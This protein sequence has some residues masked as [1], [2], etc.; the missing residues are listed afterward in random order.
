M[1]C[2]FPGTAVF[3]ALTIGSA[4]AAEYRFQTFGG[5][6]G[7]NSAV[8]RNVFAGP[9]GRVWVTSPHEIYRFDGKRF[10]TVQPAGDLANMDDVRW[11]TIF[12]DRVY[13]RVGGAIFRFGTK[14][15][16]T[17]AFQRVASGLPAGAGYNQGP[18]QVMAAGPDGQLW[19]LDA[20]RLLRLTD[21]GKIELLHDFQT[22][23]HSLLPGP[24]GGAWAGCGDGLC[25]WPGH[26]EHRY[27]GARE[28]VPK[29]EYLKLISRPESGLLVARGR[30]RLVEQSDRGFADTTG[31]LGPLLPDQ[32][33]PALAFDHQRRLLTNSEQGLARQEAGTWKFINARNGLASD[34]VRAVGVDV[35]GSIWLGTLSGGVLR[36]LGDGDWRAYTPADGLPRRGAESMVQDGEGNLWV[37]TLGFGVY[38]G[39]RHQGDWHFTREP[40]LGDGGILA[41]HDGWIW[42]ASAGGLRRFHPRRRRREELRQG[43]L[44]QHWIRQFAVDGA[45]KL[46]AVGNDGLFEVSAAGAVRK[47]L[48]E[49]IGSPFTVAPSGADGLWLGTGKGLFRYTPAGGAE[50]VGPRYGVSALGVDARG[51]LWVGGRQQPLVLFEWREG[52]FKRLRSENELGAI[53]PTWLVCTGEDLWV[54]MNLGIAARRSSV[55]YHYGVRGAPPG[56]EWRTS[57]LGPDGVFYF[58]SSGGILQYE[59]SRTQYRRTPPVVQIKAILIEGRSPH[60]GELRRIPPEHGNLSVSFA[61]PT[62]ATGLRHPAR[63][64]LLPN[65]AWAPTSEQRLD[66]IGL[67]PG[68]YTL[69][70]AARGGD[71]EWGRAAN[72]PIA[73]LPFWYQTK[74]ALSASLLLGAGLAMVA[75]YMYRRLHWLRTWRLLREVLQRFPSPVCVCGPDGQLLFS[76]RQARALTSEQQDLLFGAPG[77]LEVVTQTGAEQRSEKELPD[78]RRFEVTHYPLFRESG[79]L[80]FVCG[81]ATDVTLHHRHQEDLSELSARQTS[82]L[83]EER[84]RISRDIHDDLGQQLAGLRMS[85]SILA[86]RQLEPELRRRAES[87]AATAADASES[88]RRIASGLRPDLLDHLGLVPAIQHELTQFS[89]RT[90][91]ETAYSGPQEVPGLEPD[92]ALAAFRVVQEALSNVARHSE[93]TL[94]SVT[95]IVRPGA[96]EL[97]IADNGRG[98]VDLGSPSHRRT[99]G[100]L[101]MKER[102]RSVGGSLEV[103]D[104]G[105]AVV[106]ASIPLRGHGSPPHYLVASGK[107]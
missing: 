74:A 40:A 3:C 97:A 65:T 30:R 20:T 89:T 13:F 43:P 35:D 91:I 37:G 18:Y 39:R 75:A 38:R 27:W 16:G 60:R 93:A 4:A 94:V 77:G 32:P 8:I 59:P 52:K 50:P 86:R 104:E 42:A 62:T 23:V 80:A 49:S 92:A 11:I 73:V 53:D 58:G 34:I 21:A 68:E 14:W 31:S 25:F 9:N 76:N 87:L 90:G 102:T 82:M 57:V 5:V 103:T 66:I 85:A 44:S 64:R 84:R 56:V 6:D 22:P 100:I 101:G 19:F 98:L 28:G 105:G 70:I 54:G 10:A 88:V 17:R 47:S 51:R 63:Y 55:W 48:P 2:K 71:G 7:L 36:W 15:F 106:R 72:L 99:L 67:A 33:E 96:L 24:A 83:E 29:E 78:G 79:K 41:Y 45:G 1:N 69:E 12:S 107:S 81:V 26:G 46:W 95:S 61:I